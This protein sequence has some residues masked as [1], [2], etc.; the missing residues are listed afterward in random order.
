MGEKNPRVTVQLLDVFRVLLESP[1]A[2]WYGLEIARRAG[3]KSGTIYPILA[4]LE[5][6]GWLHSAWEGI[7]PAIA[8]RPRRRLYRLTGAGEQAVR[9]QLGDAV[10][11]LTPRDA[12][13]PKRATLRGRIA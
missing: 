3:L 2:D 7:D 1:T 6:V 5:R 4:R 12:E 9:T 11:R 10:Q 13:V 8:G